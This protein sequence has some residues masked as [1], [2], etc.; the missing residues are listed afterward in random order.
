MK[1][2]KA[3]LVGLGSLALGVCFLSVAVA[4]AQQAPTYPPDDKLGTAALDT[5]QADAGSQL[6]A[7]YLCQRFAD[8][9]THF[10]PY[11][12]LSSTQLKNGKQVVSPLGGDV[13]PTQQR[14]PRQ[15]VL[16]G[17]PLARD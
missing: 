5:T 8:G 12:D 6:L 9:E 16:S 17:V 4:S 11:L 10:G 3:L 15:G 2:L 1:R 14:M 7:Y 13:A